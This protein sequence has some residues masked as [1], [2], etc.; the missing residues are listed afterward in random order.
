MEKERNKRDRDRQTER[1]S[2]SHRKPSEYRNWERGRE[3]H[4][5]PLRDPSSVCVCTLREQVLDFHRKKQ[6]LLSPKGSCI[7]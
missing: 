5:G 2:Q 1:Q 6:N 4:R 7:P 3:S